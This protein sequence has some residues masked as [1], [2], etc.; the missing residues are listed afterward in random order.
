MA[1]I[2][3]DD[4][5]GKTGCAATTLATVLVNQADYEMIDTVAALA[6]DAIRID[7]MNIN[8]HG[9]R[10]TER[11]FPVE[12]KCDYCRYLPICILN[13]TSKNMPK[14][15]K[16]PPV[17]IETFKYLVVSIFFLIT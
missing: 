16:T 5:V 6:P 9:G 4:R 3:G 8:T 13:K 1:G 7:T 17:I 15:N 10:P 14:I 11:K 12:E 2:N